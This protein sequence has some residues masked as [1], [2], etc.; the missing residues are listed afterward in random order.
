MAPRERP[1]PTVSL[2]EAPPT[3]TGGDG[4][5]GA[6]RRVPLDESMGCALAE[7]VMAAEDV[8]PF[9]NSAMDGFAVRAEDAG[10]GPSRLRLVG[11]VAAGGVADNPL[12]PGEAIAIATGAP[13]PKGS[14]AVCMVEQATVEGTEVVLEAAVGP[15]ENVR[16]PG[17]DIARGSAVFEASTVI[18]PSHIGVL[19]SIGVSEVTVYPSARVGVVSTGDELREGPGP[20][21]HGQIHDSN[22]HAALGCGPQCRGPGRQPGR[23]R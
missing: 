3:T 11:A 13:L 4:P 9:A 21:D 12:G 8:P 20:L 6:A 19:A 10:T 17:E 15:G 16:Y 22:R 2:A 14:D 5:P 7:V 23:G 1:G 18:G